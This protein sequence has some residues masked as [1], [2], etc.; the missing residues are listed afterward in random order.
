MNYTLEFTGP[1]AVYALATLL[2]FTVIGA[3]CTL[4][5]IAGFLQA[6]WNHY[7]SGK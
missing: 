3:I 5:F 2:T 1:S 7:R 6:A 4:A